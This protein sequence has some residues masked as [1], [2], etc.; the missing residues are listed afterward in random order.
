M[1]TGYG[2]YYAWGETETKS[3]YSWY[4]YKWMTSGWSDWPY[5][6]KYQSKDGRTTA[7]WYDSDGNF[8]GD[9]KAVLETAD[10]VAV[11]KLGSMWRMPTDA[12]W[13]ELRNYCTWTSTT[14][15]GVTGYLVAG[16]KEGYTDRSIFLPAAGCRSSTSYSDVGHYGRYWSSSLNTGNSDG[17]YFVDFYSSSVLRHDYYR[18]NGYSVRPV[19]E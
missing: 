10:D 5:I 17:A 18:Y 19:Q 11:Q 2:D 15:N 16:K 9:G 12:E 8:I 3:N 7:C 4:T 1:P 6:N 14:Q 13:T